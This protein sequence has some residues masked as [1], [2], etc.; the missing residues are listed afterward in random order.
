METFRTLA[1]IRALAE[2]IRR[3]RD[4]V[5][6]KDL[7]VD[8]RDVIEAGVRP[9]KEV[10]ACLARLLDLVLEKPSRNTREYL[11]RHLK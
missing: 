11:L 2:E 6:L 3:D 1:H 7:A 8:G 4:C 5:T 9:G 10:G